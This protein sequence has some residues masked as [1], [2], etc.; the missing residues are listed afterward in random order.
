MGNPTYIYIGSLVLSWRRNSNGCKRHV[1]LIVRTRL[2]WFLLQHIFGQRLWWNY[3]VFWAHQLWL[4]C[5]VLN[6]KSVRQLL[7][8][9]Q[10]LHVFAI[11]F[12]FLA[13]TTVLLV[14]RSW[15]VG[16][17]DGIGFCTL[18]E[19][20]CF[21]QVL[22]LH[23]FGWNWRNSLVLSDIPHL[24]YCLQVFRSFFLVAWE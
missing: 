3:A 9:S 5:L 4:N 17:S 15:I 13:V 18:L 21:A 23:L 20:G 10:F 24:V 12:G 19:I 16:L 14:I 8:D 2:K 11:D 22:I 7:W 6:M 1:D